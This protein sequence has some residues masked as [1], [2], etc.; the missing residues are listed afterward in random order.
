MWVRIEEV[1][2]AGGFEF[3]S[4]E[5]EAEMLVSGLAMNSIDKD[6]I[7]IQTVHQLKRKLLKSWNDGSPTVT[8]TPGQAAVE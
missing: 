4:N 1:C 3:N 6:G 2:E 8:K 5:F 7:L